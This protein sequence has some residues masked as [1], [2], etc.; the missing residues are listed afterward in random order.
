[1]SDTEELEPPPSSFGRERA[2]QSL[3]DSFVLILGQA[4]T[5][6]DGFFRPGPPG[7]LGIRSE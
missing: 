2:F 1:M 6:G 4:E 5:R 3:D 7:V